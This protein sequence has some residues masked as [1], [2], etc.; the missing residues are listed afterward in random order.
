MKKE[1]KKGEKKEKPENKEKPEKTEKTEN[2]EKVGKA[3]KTEIKEKVEK[4]RKTEKVEKEKGK[5][6]EKGKKRV[7]EKQENN[8]VKRK[9]EKI[10]EDSVKFE[11]LRK[12]SKI[13]NNSGFFLYG[14][15]ESI[16]IGS[17]SKESD[18]ILLEP[19]GKKTKEKYKFKVKSKKGTWLIKE[20][21]LGYNFGYIFYHQD[22]QPNDLLEKVL[23]KVKNE[24]VDDV[25]FINRYD[26]AFEESDLIESEK[27][28][29]EKQ[30][31][32]KKVEKKKDED[33]IDYSQ[34]HFLFIDMENY[35]EFIQFQLEQVI[36]QKGV[37]KK[38]EK[39]FGAIVLKQ[40]TEYDYGYMIFDKESKEMIGIVYDYLNLNDIFKDSKNEKI[41]TV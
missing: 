3:E 27:K 21:T 30:Y 32:R 13:E 12:S 6:V 31:K 14:P 2:K 15:V 37:Y 41:L 23:Q 19:K 35:Q 25:F 33:E 24:K 20:T 26:W 11:E 1:N 7:N 39:A 18:E 22:F 34:R 17:K 29:F 16:I 4:K 36:Q 10:K 28:T 38:N 5:K 8:S 40:D 9:I